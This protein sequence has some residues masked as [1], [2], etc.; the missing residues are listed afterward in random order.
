MGN[1]HT[2]ERTAA[3]ALLSALLL[4]GSAHATDEF[5]GHVEL[6]LREVDVQG[7]ENKYDQYLNLDN[8]PRLFGFSARF[9]PFEPQGSMPD[10]LDVR[11][12]GL[13]GEPYESLGLTVKRHGA[14]RFRYNRQKSDYFYEDLL[15]RPED[16]SVEGSTGGDFHH[17]D[18]E[19]VRDTASV[20][21][22]VTERATLTFDFDRYEKTGDSTTTVDVERE[23]FEVDQPIDETWRNAGFGLE[24]A[25][26]RA[27]LTVSERWQRHENDYSWFLPG[28]SL[29][30][31]PAEPTELSSFF[32]NQ[33]YD[34]DVREHALAL[35]LLPT[36]KLTLTLDVRDIDLELDVDVAESSQG[37]DF[38]G[39]S[40]TR[41]LNGGGGI[42]RDT[43]LVEAAGTYAVSERIQLS[44]SVR[45][46]DLDQDG[47][48]AFDGED[49][50]SRWALE[51]LG[52]EL[53]AQFAV[54]NELSVALGLHRESRDAEIS[55][56]ATGG[57]FLREEETE[58]DGYFV[59]A[60]YQPVRGLRLSFQLEENRVDD[61]YTLASATDARAY[62]LRARYRVNDAWSLTASHR[63]TDYENDDT[64]WESSSEQ[65]ELR[66]AYAASRLTLS[67]G[68]SR[69]EVD[70]EI[71]Q[72][73][74]GG[75]RTDRFD[76]RYAGEASLWDLNADFKLTDRLELSAG[77][78]AYDN[79]G[80][81]DVRRD[82]AQLAAAYRLP[83]DYLLQLSY[84]NVDYSEGHL[85]DFDADIWE[86]S[87]RIDW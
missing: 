56:L 76:I 7:D 71:D 59:M 44:A 38:T 60:Q 29:G 8:G 63:R 37:I 73:V 53:S 1:L 61:P 20:G 40:F 28:F 23:E 18:F 83:Q 46:Y 31:D 19:R 24:Y 79:D 14:Y 2:G 42:D 30:S 35:M 36:D 52:F 54:S 51:Q 74:S 10:L 68:V 47:A 11:I 34:S 22:D 82:D 80:S 6:G 27:T 77:V 39:A 84:R 48:M 55:E 85:E 12:T 66:V 72:L 67:A 33:P 81:F 21:I 86:L 65:S 15:I 69:I 3:A 5:S 16:A 75:F 87:L 64:D 13:G 70:R 17:F 58:Q 57:A 45:H 50:T 32:L 41:D 43:T 9:A 62:R 25:W 4:A 78:R 26:E 49:T